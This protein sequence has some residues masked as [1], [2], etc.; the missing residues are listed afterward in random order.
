V[1]IDVSQG[2]TSQLQIYVDEGLAVS[3][4]PDPDEE[5]KVQER[6]LEEW[7]ELMDEWHEISTTQT[8]DRGDSSTVAVRHTLAA[9]PGRATD[10]CVVD[11]SVRARPRT[12]ATLSH[13]W[14]L[15][16]LKPGRNRVQVDVK[17]APARR[18]GVWLESLTPLAQA[19]LRVTASDD[20]AWPP[21]LPALRPEWE[22]RIDEV[23]PVQSLEG[24]AGQ[25]RS[26]AEEERG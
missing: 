18:L 11:G 23:L 10:Q 22:R 15:V 14:H 1:E 24:V 26:S 16:D 12:A 25:R 2:V 13:S 3:D 17:A 5:R 9:G 7:I 6:T 8:D 21:L 19:T 20:A 4:D